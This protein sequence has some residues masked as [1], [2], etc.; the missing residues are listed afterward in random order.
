VQDTTVLVPDLVGKT[1]EDALAAL[2]QA[3]LDAT[4][5]EKTVTPDQAGRVLAQDPAG[6]SRVAPGA[7]IKVVIGVAP[8]DTLRPSRTL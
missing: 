6:G 7:V 2:K 5:S 4:K 3:N 1:E 8:A